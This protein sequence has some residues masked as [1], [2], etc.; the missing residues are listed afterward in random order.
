MIFTANSQGQFLRKQQQLF[1]LLTQNRRLLCG[2]SPARLIRTFN[3]ETTLATDVTVLKAVLGVCRRAEDIAIASC[4]GIEWQLRLSWLDLPQSLRTLLLLAG[5]HL[6]FD[7]ASSAAH[8]TRLRVL[9][10]W[11]PHHVLQHILAAAGPQITQL[12]LNRYWQRPDA[13]VCSEYLEQDSQAATS[14]RGPPS[15]RLPASRHSHLLNR[16][17]HLT[18]DTLDRRCPSSRQSLRHSKRQ[19]TLSICKCNLSWSYARSTRR[20]DLASL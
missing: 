20:L 5:S 7:T 6:L 13:L 11:V 10:S 19:C 18:P 4:H 16:L 14:V 2:Q 17:R 15:F 3:V 12:S 1:L 9:H 8:L